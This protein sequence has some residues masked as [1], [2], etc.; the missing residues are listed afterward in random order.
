MDIIRNISRGSLNRRFCSGQNF[1]LFPPFLGTLLSMLPAFFYSCGYAAEDPGSAMT[2]PVTKVSLSCPD[3]RIGT[4]DIFVFNDNVFR[5][6]DCYQRFDDMAGWRGSVV[7]SGG[8]RIISA[9]AN[10]PYGKSHWLGM[11]SRKFLDDVHMNLEDESQGNPIMFGEI[12]VDTYNSDGSESL[13]LRPLASEIRLNSICCDFTGKA[14]DGERLTDVRVYLTNV[15][16]ECRLSD[17]GDSPPIRI[18]NAGRLDED[19]MEGFKDP[20]ILMRSIGGEIGETA[21]KSSFSLWCYQSCH[22][23]ETPGSP[24]TRLVIEGKIS[25]HTYYWP[26][27]INRGMEHGYGIRRGVCHSY[28]ITITRKGTSNPDIPAKAEDITINH[29]VR[30]WNEK[31]EYEVRF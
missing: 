7:S 20:G 29:T 8:K 4:L 12:P 28:D 19:D 18:V 14:Y 6:L 17:D 24:F 30:R 3:E 2:E 27:N 5:N 15:N 11:N 21:L 10:S 16:A 1:R 13:K 25:G 23:D 31:E 22:K 9:L 26:I